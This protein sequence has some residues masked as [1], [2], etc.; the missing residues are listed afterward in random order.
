MG[1]GTLRVRPVR[2]YRVARY[3]SRHPNA[4]MRCGSPIRKRLVRAA[5]APAVALG[6]GAM[7]G[8]CEGGVSLAGT[9]P[10]APDAT[11]TTTDVVEETVP[12]EVGEDDA[13]TE[14]AVP[15]DVVAEDAAVDTFD[16]D[17]I[18]PGDMV[19]GTH[20]TR[21][22]GEAEGRAILAG[23]V[24]EET[25][26]ASGPCATPTLADRLREDQPFGGGGFSIGVDLLAPALAIEASPECPGALRVAVGL[27]FMTDEA[28][29]D[30]DV[31]GNPAG[32]TDA[33]EAELRELDARHEAHVRPLP[34]TDY[35]F[36][37]WEYE[38]GTI[39]DS[40]RARAEGLLRD[41]VR[42]IVDELKRDGCI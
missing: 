8:A 20:Y 17:A 41:T 30:E 12:V 39:D 10:D 18:F 13:G 33:E 1:H 23:V 4:R 6:L 38:D 2:R 11:E 14:D 9:D 3:P 35:A 15:E 32:L 34:A 25:G 36:D 27:E 19:Y 28:G 21:Y 29:D 22:F 42:A 16:P 40:D 26:T 24:R 37:V 31:S 5:A 7:G